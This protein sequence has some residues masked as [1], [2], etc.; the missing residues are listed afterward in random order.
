MQE[1]EKYDVIKKEI[2]KYKNYV[3]KRVLNKKNIGKGVDF[4]NVTFY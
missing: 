1:V 3:H 2:L 4:E